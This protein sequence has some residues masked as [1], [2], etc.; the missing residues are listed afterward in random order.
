MISL[1]VVEAI[2]LYYLIYSAGVILFMAWLASR[3]TKPRE[4]SEGG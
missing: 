4:G 3:L 2:D 1:G